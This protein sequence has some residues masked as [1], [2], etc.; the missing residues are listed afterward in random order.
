MPI[1]SSLRL[2]IGSN[3]EY[4]GRIRRVRKEE[5]EAFALLIDLAAMEKNIKKEKKVI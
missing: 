5:I 3:A 2:R 1:L 4:L